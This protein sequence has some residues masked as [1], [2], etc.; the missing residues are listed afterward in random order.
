MRKNWALK[1]LYKMKSNFKK[2][3]IKAN[4]LW[5]SRVTEAPEA[6]G[7]VGRVWMWEHGLPRAVQ[8]GHVM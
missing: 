1:V 4:V 5:E 2:I 3:L 6:F 8:R 7:Q